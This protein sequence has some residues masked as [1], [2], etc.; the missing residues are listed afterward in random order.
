M[1]NII[2]YSEFSKLYEDVAFASANSNGM[3]NVVSP[4][5]SSVPGFVGGSTAGSGDVASHLGPYTKTATDGYN[6]M[7]KRGKKKSK[8]R[9]K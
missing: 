4:T 5:V 2:K 1:K 9:K 7:I 3:G 6:S 8:K